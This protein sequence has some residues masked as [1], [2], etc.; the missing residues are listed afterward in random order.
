MAAYQSE[1]KETRGLGGALETLQQQPLGSYM[2]GAM[3]AGLVL[4]GAFMF[5]V[6]RYRYIDSS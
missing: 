5:L 6:A 3:A 1:P 4:Y 2:L